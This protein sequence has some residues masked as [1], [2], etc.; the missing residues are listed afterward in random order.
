MDRYIQDRAAIMEKTVVKSDPTLEAAA[1][2]ARV[3]LEAM[4]DDTTDAADDE[5]WRKFGLPQKRK[6]AL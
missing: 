1:E 3:A 2:D 6:R 5:Y 4:E